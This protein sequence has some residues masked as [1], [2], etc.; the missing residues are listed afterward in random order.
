LPGGGHPG[1][2]SGDPGCGRHSF[3]DGTFNLANYQTSSQLLTGTG[4]SLVP[5]QCTNC[6][7]PGSALQVTATFPNPPVPPASFDLAYQAFVNSGFLYNPATQGAITSLFASVDKNLS[8]NQPSGP[9]PFANTFHPT[10]EQGGI[11]YFASIPGPSLSTGAGRWVKRFSAIRAPVRH[12][13][14]RD[15]RLG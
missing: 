15:A 7:N 9:T 5:I 8:V 3:T 1:D 14:P 2:G 12:L 13:L 6:G 11:F 4:T 10:I